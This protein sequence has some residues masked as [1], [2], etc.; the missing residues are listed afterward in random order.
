MKLP[1]KLY[2]EAGDGGSGGGG[3]DGSGAGAG[4]SGGDAGAGG[5]GDG[6][7]GGG[8]G[9][10]GTLLSGGAGSGGAAEGQGGA[11]QGGGAAGGQG[12]GGAG[13]AEGA[14]SGAG[15]PPWFVG[16]YDASGKIN[17]KAFD[18]LP[19]HLK[20]HKDT[21]AKYQTVDALLGGM[22]NLANLAGKKGLQPL[23]KDAPA[24]LVA[25]RQVLMRQLNNTPEKPDGYGIKK[26]DGTPDEQWNGEYVN[27]VL[28]ILHKHNAS[29]DLVKELV[30]FDGEF[31]G[32]LRSGSE[33]Q[34]V[35]A[36]KQ[37]EAALKE[38]FGS[39]YSK[40]IDAATRAA[41]T[42]GLD[43][44]SDPIFRSSKAVIA[45]AKV[46]EMVSE[47]RL[48]SGNS[49]TG[50]GESDRTKALDIINN[51]SNP[52]YKAYH[53]AEHPQH[54]AALAQVST[55]NQR[56]AQQKAKGNRNAA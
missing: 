25:E 50:F 40:K 41:R 52:L 11:G 45:M 48:V 43:P 47:D 51:E 33:A 27:G 17:A 30:G 36:L 42:L 16:L 8:S 18:A 22:G 7:A 24:E 21:F 4:A 53:D 13:G 49:D 34:Q 1:F 10:S 39:D 14:A 9:G 23:P 29:P 12:S 32:K 2:D 28:G 55:F 19:E 46:A 6:G 26:P 38:A 35:Q 54:A 3:G 31:A 20:A 15:A 37:E 44:E 56:W 5:G